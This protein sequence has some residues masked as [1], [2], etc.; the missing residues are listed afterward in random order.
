VSRF[1]KASAGFQGAGHEAD[2]DTAMTLRKGEI[3]RDDLK[4]RWP[5]HAAL[6]AEQVRDPVNRE[7]IFR[8]AWVLSTSPPTYFMRRDDS[9]LVVFGFANPEAAEAFAKHFG[10]ERL[11]KNRR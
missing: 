2:G 9:D 1:A 10:G 5:H 11:P 8:A 6:P 4:R 3:T 7:V